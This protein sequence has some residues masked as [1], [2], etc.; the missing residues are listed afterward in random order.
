IV[1][2]YLADYHT[3]YTDFNISFD[4]FKP[5]FLDQRFAEYVSTDLIKEVTGVFHVIVGAKDFYTQK[6][7]LIVLP[8]ETAIYDDVSNYISNRETWESIL[9]FDAYISLLKPR[10][11]N[12]WGVYLGL[13]YALAADQAKSEN[14]K[15]DYLA[16]IYQLHQKYFN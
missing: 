12:E 2:F 13:F 3:E 5:T 14:S 11:M 6:D 8:N 9:N 16:Q 4:G 7:G 10:K 15:D 1:N